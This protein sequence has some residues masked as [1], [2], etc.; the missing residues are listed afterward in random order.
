MPLF[1]LHYAVVYALQGDEDVADMVV[2]MVYEVMLADNKASY[3]SLCDQYDIAYIKDLEEFEFEPKV[4]D[5]YCFADH[6]RCIHADPVCLPCYENER[7][8]QVTTY[9]EIKSDVEFSAFCRLVT[10]PGL[11][12]NIAAE[13]LKKATRIE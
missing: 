12:S 9:I 13:L 6:L 7:W 11:P 1:H 4:L 5:P 3:D 8:G 10:R 2:D